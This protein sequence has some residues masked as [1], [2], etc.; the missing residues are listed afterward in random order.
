MPAHGRVINSLNHRLAL[1]R[2]GVHDRRLR[3]AGA[4]RRRRSARRRPRPARALRGARARRPRR[5]RRDARRLHRATRRCSTTASRPGARSRARHAGGDLLHR[6]HD[7][8]AEGRHAQPRQP[9]GQRQALPV[10]GRAHAG[11]P[12][13]PRRADV[14]RR[15]LDDGL[16]RHLG[17]WRAH[18]ARPLRPASPRACHR[19]ARR[20]RPRARA[21]H[22]P[23]AARAPRAAS[24]R[25]RRPAAA[26]LRGGADVREPARAGDAHAVVRLPARVRHD[27][28]GAGRHLPLAGRPPGRPAPALRRPCDP[29]RA[30]RDPRSLRP[31]A[32]GRRGGGGVRAR[33]ER[34]ARGTGTATR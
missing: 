4:R 28:G 17:R 2:A 5:R 22:D 19:G 18:P 7:R 25:P 29:G 27:R 20:D 16:L 1:A 15:R 32:A 13:R 33:A 8:S 3:N 9:R 23:D 6:R 14:P 12:L 24:G 11:G 30:D 34:D 26:A 21:D 31:A 10:P